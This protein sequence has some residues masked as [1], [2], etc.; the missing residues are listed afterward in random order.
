M[1]IQ[2]TVN[3]NKNKAVASITNA[4]TTQFMLSCDIAG[5]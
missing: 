3:E 1:S 5:G 2:N 4:H